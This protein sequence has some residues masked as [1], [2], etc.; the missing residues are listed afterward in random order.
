MPIKRSDLRPGDILL[1]EDTPDNTTGTHKGIRFG[2]RLT[3]VKIW[4]KNKGNT[5]CV[6]ALIWTR[7]QSSDTPDVAEA[8][9]SGWVRTIALPRGTYKV[10]QCKN[11]DL[12]ELAASTALLWAMG[13]TIEYSR[14][15][16]ISSVF[17]SDKLG[18]RGLNRAQ[19]Y[20]A[21]AQSSSPAWGGSGAFCSQF[22]VACYQAAA[23]HNSLNLGLTG[24][25][26]R[27][28]AK[29]CSVRALHDR[30]FR[31]PGFSLFGELDYDVEDMARL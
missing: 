20:A 21:D 7:K 8:S 30:L 14:P 3:S 10:Y 22:I 4:R 16:A 12:G 15:K 25:L 29:H 28:D 6:H 24:E 19:G 17:H 26:L 27:C 11:Q 18:A 1:L 2:Q 31:D 9:G 23:L 5:K 13:G